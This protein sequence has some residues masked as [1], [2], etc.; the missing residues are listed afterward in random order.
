M[1]SPP[2][3][4]FGGVG[5][6]GGLE[7]PDGAFGRPGSLGKPEPGAGGAAFTAAAKAAMKR[8]REACI[9]VAVRQIENLVVNHIIRGEH[10]ACILYL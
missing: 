9:V 3:G 2:P 5:A 1:S 8:V 6:V 10:K 4:V 7:R